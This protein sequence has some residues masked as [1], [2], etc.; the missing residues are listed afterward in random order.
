[1][2]KYIRSLYLL[3]KKSYD[4]NEI[5]VGSIVIYKDKIIGKGYNNRQSKHNVCGHAEVNAIIAAEKYIGDWRLNDC[6][7]ISTLHPCKMC[8]KIIEESRISKVYY[9]YPQDNCLNK[10]YEQIY[11]PGNNYCKKIGEMFSNFF[12]N[13]R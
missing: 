7:L 11:F 1:M 9:I 6:I 13:M 2:K 10:S 5:P 4:I 12:K 3:T 8:Q